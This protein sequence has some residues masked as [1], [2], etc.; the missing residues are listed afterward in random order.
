M[1]GV[2]GALASSHSYLAAAKTDTCRHVR[3]M[4]PHQLVVL[5]QIFEDPSRDLQKYANKKE[6]R[7]CFSACRRIEMGMTRK[8]VGSR[9]YG[10]I[11]MAMFMLMPGICKQQ[12][13]SLSSS[14]SLLGIS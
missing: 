8:P 2:P 4:Q 12:Q 9:E 7:K 6:A 5:A 1:A 13:K 11:V 10:H 14:W 3:P